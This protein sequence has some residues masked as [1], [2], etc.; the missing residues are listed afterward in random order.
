M[1]KEHPAALPARRGVLF[2]A[3]REWYTFFIILMTVFRP[4]I[5]AIAGIIFFSIVSISTIH[6]LSRFW[7]APAPSSPQVVLQKNLVSGS[8]RIPVE[9][10]DTPA[11]LELGLSGRDSLPEPTGMLFAFPAPGSY[12]FWMKDMKFPLDMI[13][14]DTK[15]VVVYIKASAT[16]DSYPQIFGSQKEAQYVLEVNTGFAAKNGIKIGTKFELK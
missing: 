5:I 10:S 4:L 6:F 8:L 7:G 9:I 3:V 1:C 12:G 2:A 13:W 15:M 14:L 11:K 16:P